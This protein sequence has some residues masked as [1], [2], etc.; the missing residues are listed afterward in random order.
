MNAP[1]RT[2]LEKRHSPSSGSQG[3]TERITTSAR[4]IVCLKKT[5]VCV[6][7]DSFFSVRFVA[8]R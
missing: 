6:F 2:P 7:F 3:I 5:H 8:K 4:L 1:K